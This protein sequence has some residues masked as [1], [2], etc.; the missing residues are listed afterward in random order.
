MNKTGITRRAIV[1]APALAVVGCASRFQDPLILQSDACYLEHRPGTELG[2]LTYQAVDRLK[3][4]AIPV[5]TPDVPIIVASISDAQRLDETSKFGNLIA[6]LVKSR[7]SQNCLTVAEERLR[8]RMHLKRDEGEMMLA[9]DANEIIPPPPYA[10]VA[11]GTYAVGD[12]RVYVSLKLIRR[13]SARIMSSVDFVVWKTA[14]VS[15]L[16]GETFPVRT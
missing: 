9:R 3:S 1:L 4:R 12:E 14:D 7:L 5:L 6:D 8:S 15:R 16:L 13:D 10:S 11:T 2:G